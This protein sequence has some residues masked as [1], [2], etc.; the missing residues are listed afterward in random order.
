MTVSVLCLLLT[1][2][3]VGLQYVIVAFPGRTH[4]LF[5]IHVLCECSADR[6]FTLN[7]KPCLVIYRIKYCL[8]QLSVAV[9]VL[10]LFLAMP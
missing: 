6:G 9:C 8:N 3:R 1:V 7:V 4:L 2:P 5:D 10:C